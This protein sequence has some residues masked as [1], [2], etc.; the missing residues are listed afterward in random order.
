MTKGE[1]NR[2]FGLPLQGLNMFALLSSGTVDVFVYC[3]LFSSKGGPIGWPYIQM[4]DS[5]TMY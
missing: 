1:K 2:A 4:S 3:L 5:K